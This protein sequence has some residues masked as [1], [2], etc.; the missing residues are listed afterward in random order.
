MMNTVKNKISE[1]LIESTSGIV[2]KV[3]IPDM[4]NPQ[5]NLHEASSHKDY[6]KFPYSPKPQANT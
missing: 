5:S 4:Y 2:P 6:G 1:L 3:L